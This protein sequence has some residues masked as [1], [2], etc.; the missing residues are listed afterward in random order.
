MIINKLQAFYDGA[1]F[2]PSGDTYLTKRAFVL[3][4]LGYMGGCVVKWIRPS[5]SIL[6]V[7]CAVTTLYAMPFL[8]GCVYLIAGGQIEEFITKKLG[9]YLDAALAGSGFIVGSMWFVFGSRTFSA[10]P[11]LTST[12]LTLSFAIALVA[13]YTFSNKLDNRNFFIRLIHSSI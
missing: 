9:K 12:L 3:A 2:N 8:Y 1:T 5:S 11:I 13:D 10:N 4:G 7:G 6:P